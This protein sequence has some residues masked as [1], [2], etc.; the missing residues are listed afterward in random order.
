MKKIRIIIMG[1]TGVG[2][3]TIIN[4]V[5]G[6]EKAKIGDGAAITRENKVYDCKRMVDFSDLNSPGGYSKVNYEISLYDTVGLEV[7]SRITRDTLS[8]IKEHIKEAKKKSSDEDVN[9]VWFCINERSNRFETYEADLIKQ[10]SN[11]FEI[12]F[13][14]VLTKC[15]S[16]KSGKLAEEIQNKMPNI[17]IRRILASDYEFDDDVIIKAYGLEE[18]LSMSINDYYAYRIQVVDSIIDELSKQSDAKIKEIEKKGNACIIKYT[19]AAGK[20]GRIPGGCIPFVHSKCIKMISDL[21]SIGG[22]SRDKDYASEI[23]DD[24]I[25]GIVMAPFMALPFISKL[26]AES[27]LES[28]GEN[29]LKAMIN[30]ISQSSKAELNDK[31]L[32]KERM[33]QQLKK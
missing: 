5:L 16:K 19:E 31:K 22:L 18:L 12:P 13:V 14:I 23:F 10:L 17:P 30:V 25:V 3:S 1:K 9:I 20:I 4:A 21:N 24:I 29:Y 26:A 32:V 28:V 8:K 11:E 6:E 33:R 2:K 15:I 27:Y 7:D